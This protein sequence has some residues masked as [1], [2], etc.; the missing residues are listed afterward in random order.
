MSRRGFDVIMTLFLRHVP[1]GV[2]F[3]HG[4]DA[5]WS[6]VLYKKNA[7]SDRTFSGC[8]LDT[9]LSTFYMYWV[10]YLDPGSCRNQIK[11]PFLNLSN[12][13]TLL[14]SSTKS[15]SN[16]LKCLHLTI[17][18]DKISHCTN[19]DLIHC[20]LATIYCD[21]HLGQHWLKKW[22]VVWQHQAITWTSVDLSPT[23]VLC[24]IHLRGN[25]HC[26]KKFS[27]PTDTWRNNNVIITSDVATS[28]WCNN[29]IIAP[30]AHWVGLIRKMCCTVFEY[31]TFEM[32]LPA[33]ESSIKLRHLP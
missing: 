11:L 29:D 4:Y 27:C 25:S 7:S 1:L 26:N 19:Y 33:N 28:C 24:D 32:Y 16:N 5:V 21:M 6:R 10:A 30:C 9:F 14:F 17:I 8:L 12:Y 2:M 13:C 15:D 20:D 22:L 3:L 23:T 18:K 31:Y